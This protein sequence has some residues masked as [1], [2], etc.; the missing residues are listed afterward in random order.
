MITKDDIGL[1]I[2][3]AGLTYSAEDNPVYMR[4]KTLDE[5]INAVMSV[6]GDNQHE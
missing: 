4:E 6:I 5:V 2:I 3:N 1:A